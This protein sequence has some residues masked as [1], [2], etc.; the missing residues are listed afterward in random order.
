[1]PRDPFLPLNRQEQRFVIH[2][3]REGATPEVAHIA[4]RKARLKK[5][6][7]ANLLRRKHIQEEIHRRKVLVEFEEN[8][9]IAKDSIEKAAAIDERDKVTLHKIESALDKVIALDPEKHGQTVLKGI[10]L[11]LIYTGSI[12]DGNKVKLQVVDPLG[13][14]KE[15]PDDGEMKP[16]EEGFYASIFSAMKDTGSGSGGTPAAVAPAEL[17][18]EEEPVPAAPKPPAPPAAKATAVAKPAA[19]AKKTAPQ[20]EIT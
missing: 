4:E 1:M 17:M 19:A 20:I 15:K 3:L 16:R 9:L 12:R 6:E 10:E 11:G 2:Y 14:E 13:Q 5:G 8:R 18:P 7:G